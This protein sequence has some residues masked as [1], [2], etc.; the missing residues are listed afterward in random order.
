[1][2]SCVFTE[3][4]KP[5]LQLEDTNHCLYTIQTALNFAASSF[6]CNIILVWLGASLSVGRRTKTNCY[7]YNFR[8]GS[9][10]S[11]GEEIVQKCT[12]PVRE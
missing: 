12:S 7:D 11:K 3:V 2:V 8:R 10:A 9:Y 6:C 1:M 4:L 5:Q